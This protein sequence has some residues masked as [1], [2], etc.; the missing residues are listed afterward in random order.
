MDF[1]SNPKINKLSVPVMVIL[2]IGLV[3]FVLWPVRSSILSAK[4]SITK[5][6]INLEKQYL[7]GQLLKKTQQQ[8]K[9][10]KPDIPRVKS[11]ILTRGQELFVI[12]TFEEIAKRHSL[13]QHIIMDDLVIDIEGDDLDKV[14]ALPT[15]VD[16]NG[17]FLDVLNY[18]SDVEALG[19]YVNWQSV[20]IRT[21]SG[22]K[23]YVP[24][25]GLAPQNA[26]GLTTSYEILKVTLEGETYWKL[27]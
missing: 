27:Q 21:S 7:N 3:V 26:P 24:A 23:T 11:A 19:F 20:S 17:D 14:I 22:S 6:R 10:I 25:P 9:G 5:E 13:E 16:L 2:I 18:L 12:T 4:A 1:L 8:F 15:R